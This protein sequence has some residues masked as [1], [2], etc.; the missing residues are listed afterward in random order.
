MPSVPSVPTLWRH[1]ATNTPLS[2]FLR[3]QENS[4]YATRTN[5]KNSCKMN[6]IKQETNIPIGTGVDRTCGRS[7]AR[8]RQHP[9][10]NIGVC[11]ILCALQTR[12]STTL[13]VT[14]AVTHKR[15]RSRKHIVARW[16]G[17]CR[18]DNAS[19]CVVE[20]LQA[21][22]WCARN[23][24]CC[25]Y[26]CS[27]VQC[28]TVQ[29]TSVGGV[30]CS[31]VALQTTRRLGHCRQHSHR[32]A[33]EHHSLVR[34]RNETCRCSSKI[35]HSTHILRTRG[36]A[37][38]RTCSAS[39]GTSGHATTL[40]SRVYVPC[41]GRCSGD[42]HVDKGTSCCAAAQRCSSEGEQCAVLCG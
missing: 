39:D 1:G 34:A 17:H 26:S 25:S 24:G 22:H 27:H 16:Q 19:C 33:R 12:C 4:Q 40:K 38:K 3:I 41:A 5:I 28:V 6:N 15:A 32:S 23:A 7:E 11:S 30:P 37:G 10:P 36:F 31:T 29:E 13:C 21:L 20:G 18:V 35:V 14:I 2:F 8:V 42:G 9:V